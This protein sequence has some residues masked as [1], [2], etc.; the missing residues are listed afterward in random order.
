MM[1]EVSAKTVMTAAL[2]LLLQGAAG[3]PASGGERHLRLQNDTR[4]PIVEI[5]V[6]DAGADRWQDDL[7]GTDFLSPGDSVLV[8]IEDRNGRCRVD[9]KMVLDNGSDIVDRGVDVCGGYT[10]SVR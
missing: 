3:P 1:I 10:V 6:S 7:L 9:V 2:S 5:H 4:E 8:E